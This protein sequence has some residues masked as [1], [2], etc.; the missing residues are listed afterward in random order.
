MIEPN[1]KLDKGDIR[2]NNIRV[3]F[4]AIYRHGSVT[5]AQLARETGMSVMA[6]GRIADRLIEQKLIVDRE[7]D[8]SAAPGRPARRLYLSPD[9]ASVGLS[10][11]TD[12]VVI[13]L[14]SPYGQVLDR[15]FHG[16]SPASMTPE[17]GLA[18]VA[19][20]TAAFLQKHRVSDTQAIGVVMPGL[21]EY[22]RAYLRFTSQLRWTDVPVGDLLRERLPVRTVILDNDVKARAQ[23]ESR[24]FFGDE[25]PRMVLLHIGSGIGAGVIIDN[26]IYRGKDNLAGEIG[27]T[28]LNMS[29]RMCECGRLGCLQ[30]TISK[31][32]I[33]EEA[34]TVS[35][36]V[37]MA[38]LEKAYTEGVSWAK[39]LLDMTAESV[40]VLIN[41]L[42]NAYAPDAIVLCGSLVEKCDVLRDLISQYHKDQGAS[43]LNTNYALHYSTVGDAGSTI[44]A[45]TIAFNE[46]VRWMIANWL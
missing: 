23:A 6:V 43:V 7:G 26:R 30:A 1:Q 3:L 19:D 2:Q 39:A 21:I 14:V 46:N 4:E 24:L 9:I 12:G 33:L 41:L 11:D 16:F 45:A 31:Q 40:L 34:R 37:D 27:H 42:A 18:I 13:G 25:Y 44:G 17:E 28:S 29:R 35:P 22:E 15:E 32:A 38:G 8:D 36:N 5:K 10:L 20:K